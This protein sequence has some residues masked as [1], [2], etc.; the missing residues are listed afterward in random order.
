MYYLIKHQTNYRY[1]SPISE[2]QMEVRMQPR[3]DGPQRCC[4]FQLRTMP[5]SKVTSYRDRLGNVVHH[6][7]V[8]ARHDRLSI[9]AEASS[10][11]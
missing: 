8:P 10:S 7:D 3:T 1:S 4:D 2:S 11:R 9:T 5:L 6:F